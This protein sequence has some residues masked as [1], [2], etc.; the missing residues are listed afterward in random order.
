M[1]CRVRSLFGAEL[2]RGQRRS[3][4]RLLESPLFLL[5]QFIGHEPE[6]CGA[7]RPG[8]GCPANRL[9]WRLARQAGP[10]S[11]ERRR[12]ACATAGFALVAVL[13]IIMLASMVVVSLMFRLK[14]ENTALSAGAGSEQA[15]AAAM[16]G[17]QEALRVVRENKPGALDWQDAPRSFQNHFVFDDGADQWYFTVYSPAGSDSLEP[18]RYGLTDEAGKLNLN[19]ATETNLL[20]LPR[21]TASLVQTLL[22]FLDADNT[23]RPEGAEQEYYDALPN[24][25]TI[26]NGPLA[27]LDELLLV[28]GFSPAL[29]DGE[30]VNRNFIL[31]V[32]ENDGDLTFPPD[33]NDSKLDLGL[34]P[35]LTVSSSDLN[36]DK[37]GV[38]RTDLNDPDDPL[39]KVELPEALV[40]YILAMR[41]N[42][43]EIAQPADLLEAKAKIKD[44]N[45]KEI[46]LPSGVGKA[47]F[48][49]VLDLFSTTY[50]E[51]LVGLINVNT[52]SAQVLATLP[53]IDEGLAESIVSARRGLTEEK[54]QTIAW[55]YTE[56]VVSAEV[57][58]KIAP[59]LTARSWQYSFHVVG[60]GV[61][62]GRF[63]VFEVIVDTVPGKTEI[64]YLRE[65]TRLGLPFKMDTAK[66][67]TGG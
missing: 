61:P 27:T 55:L 32:N 33:N 22:D 30:D 14:A 17:V 19:V 67:E 62:S 6:G 5:D 10:L 66:E 44:A 20:R 50:D 12:D 31:D 35:V 64:A 11:D 52:A 43:L 29:L 53:E 28:R 59:Y 3:A 21:M 8:C 49:L 36:Q 1:K 7:V 57:F 37:D 46:E 26:R 65:L 39:P 24:P 16:S 15:W 9:G 54:R 47:E 4:F 2:T 18:I 41:T 48:P 34:R 56:D 13:I 60:Y 63:R 23:P 45:G 51:L 40:N 42:K 58:K 38:P 25:Y